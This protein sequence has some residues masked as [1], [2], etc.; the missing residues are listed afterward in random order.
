MTNRMFLTIFFFQ[1]QVFLEAIKDG[2]ITLGEPP[3]IRERESYDFIPFKTTCPWEVSEEYVEKTD[4][5]Y[6]PESLDKELGPPR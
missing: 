4:K 5:L 1:L 3:Q 2:G 6:P